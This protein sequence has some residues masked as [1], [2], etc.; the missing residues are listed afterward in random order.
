MMVGARQRRPLP[1]APYSLNGYDCFF[2]ANIATIDIFNCPEHSENL[3]T[4]SDNVKDIVAGVEAFN[5]TSNI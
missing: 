3:N 1:Q 4:A 2:N 5:N